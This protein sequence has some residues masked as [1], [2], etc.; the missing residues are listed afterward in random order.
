LRHA[1]A[2]HARAGPVTPDDD[3][4]RRGLPVSPARREPGV[5]PEAAGRVLT[6]LDLRTVLLD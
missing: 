6:R 3:G 4:R 5:D 1:R 2:R